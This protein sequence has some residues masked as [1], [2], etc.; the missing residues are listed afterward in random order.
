ME[1]LFSRYVNERLDLSGYS[2]LAMAKNAVG[3][4]IASKE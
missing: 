3:L 4:A 1:K 2:P